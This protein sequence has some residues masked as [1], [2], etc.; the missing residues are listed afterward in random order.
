DPV[1]TGVETGYEIR[2]KNEGSAPA[3]RVA[4]TCELPMGCRFVSAAGAVSHAARGQMVEF[5]PIGRIAP[6]ETVKYQVL[7][8]GEVAGNL[9]FRTHLTS[10]SI[11]DPLTSEELTKFYE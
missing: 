7:I 10:D 5:R 2:V 4:L 6:G 8:R 1:E 9:R 11:T 3:E